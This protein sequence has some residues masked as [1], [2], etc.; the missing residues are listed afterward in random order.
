MRVVAP[1]SYLRLRTRTGLF[2]LRLPTT[3]HNFPISPMRATCKTHLHF[4][5]YR[6]IMQFTVQKL[7][8]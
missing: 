5:E 8:N 2:T 6:K 3:A 4:L 1:L 7:E